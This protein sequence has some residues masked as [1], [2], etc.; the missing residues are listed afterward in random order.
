MLSDVVAWWFVL[1]F[2]WGLY[3]AVGVAS[4]SDNT[5]LPTSPTWKPDIG[6]QTTTRKEMYDTIAIFPISHTMSLMGHRTLVRK[7]MPN[8]TIRTIP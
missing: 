3:W 2:F 4:M 6:L 1:S 5:T 8:D 7:E